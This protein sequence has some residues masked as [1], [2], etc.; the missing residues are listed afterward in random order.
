MLHR[1]CLLCVFG[2]FA[3]RNGSSCVSLL[4]QGGPC[5]HVFCLV[6]NVVGRI[7]ALVEEKAGALVACLG[8]CVALPGPVGRF[9]RASAGLVHPGEECQLARFRGE[10]AGRDVGFDRG[11]VRLSFLVR[12]E[13]ETLI[14]ERRQICVVSL[15]TWVSG[16]LMMY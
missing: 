8:R 14:I 3:Q 7:L 1:A 4:G 10:R 11:M 15:V 13:K 12:K 6:G 16:M 9:A 5:G 2:S